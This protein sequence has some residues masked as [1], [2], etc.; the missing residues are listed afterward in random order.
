MPWL[1]LRLQ[2]S[3]SNAQ[4]QSLLVA[5][6]KV[7]CSTCL[8]QVHRAFS[9]HLAPLPQDGCSRQPLPGVLLQLQQRLQAPHQALLPMSPQSLE[10]PAH[11]Q[12][13]A[14]AQRH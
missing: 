1:H 6:R 8:P 14:A 13:A 10:H 3:R 11:Q 4:M 12:L 9:R 2:S 5:T 7:C